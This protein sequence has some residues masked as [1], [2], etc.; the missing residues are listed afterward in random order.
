MAA[1]PARLMRMFPRRAGLQA[2]RV[3]TRRAGLQACL[4]MAI[5]SAGLQSGHLSAQQAPAIPRRI[6]SLIPATTEMLFA[7]G[8][9]DRLVGVSNYDHFPAAVNRLPRVGG[10]IDPSVERLLSLKPD[11]VLVYDTQADLKQ[12]LA[13][14]GIPVFRYE[15]RDLA[16]ITRTLRTLGERV[17]AA[18]AANAAARGFEQRLA[19]IKGRVAGLAR[20]RALLVFAREAG[21]LR[22]VDASGGY[23]FL[24]DLLELA[25]G[26]DVLADIKQQSVQMSTEM[27]LSRAPEVIIE[28]H[29]GDTLKTDNFDAERKVWN[30]LPSIPAVRTGRVYL[31]G[32]DEF[33]VPGPRIVNVAE[34]FAE[35]L[36]PAGK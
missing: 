16:D 23:G 3:L 5:C 25:G 8:A 19:S 2:C 35:V 34:R 24:H 31:L 4:A 36:H 26:R 1:V 11:L 32:G 18:A 10:L 14:A 7:M 13:R 30:V 21:A 22:Q 12:Q 29:Y 15:H 20:P 6:V 9:G 28:L 17:G 27:I 33:V